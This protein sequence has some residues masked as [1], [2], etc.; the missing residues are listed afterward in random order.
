MI[1]FYLKAPSEA[2]AKAAAKASGRLLVDADDNWILASHTHA[3]DP[4]IKVVAVD[5]ILDQDGIPISP[6]VYEEG[7]FANLRVRTA[8]DIPSLLA[9]AAPLGIEIKTPQTP[10]R[11]WA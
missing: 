1:D 8:E 9:A 7:W 2:A 5:A 11:V 6:P 3:F 4:D 10:S